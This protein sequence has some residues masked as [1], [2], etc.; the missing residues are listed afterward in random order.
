MTLAGT[1]PSWRTGAH[2]SEAG[3]SLVLVPLRPVPATPLPVVRLAGARSLVL[4]AGSPRASAAGPRRG[5]PG[6]VGNAEVP[7]PTL[8]APPSGPAGVRH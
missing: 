7:A 6:D 3:S 1:G 5:P 8:V 4:G 2:W